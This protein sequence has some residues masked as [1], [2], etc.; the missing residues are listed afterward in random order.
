MLISWVAQ[1][2]SYVHWYTK[3]TNLVFF[4]NF[5]LVGLES[6]SIV[7]AASLKPRSLMPI[8]LVA[9]DFGDPPK[10]YLLVIFSH[11][12]NFSIISKVLSA[13]VGPILSVQKVELIKVASLQFII[14]S[15][16]TTL[17]IGYPLPRD[18]P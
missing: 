9:Q 8:V 3:L 1:T 14:S 15:F 6:T 17:V 2:I 10:A 13:A 12:L 5:G 11:D 4:R 18:L 16:P 7:G